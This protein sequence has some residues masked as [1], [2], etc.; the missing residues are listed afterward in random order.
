MA[1]TENTYT[2]NGATVLFTFTFPYLEQEHVKVSLDGVDTT[3]Y[4]FANATTVQMNSAPANGVIVRVYR[5]TY[6]DERITT[7]F[8]GSPIKASDL[9]SGFDQVL[10]VS[11][12]TRDNSIDK[13]DPAV[14]ADFDFNNNKGINLASPSDGADAA[15][16]AY[17]DSLIQ[18]G[19]A[20]AAAAAASA[21]AAATSASDA[22]ATYDDL[23]DR[24]LGPKASDPALDNNGNA[25]SVGA[26]YFNTTQDI[27]KAWTGT[28]WVISAAAGNIVRWRKTAS[29]GETV[30]S[31]NDDLAVTLDYAVGN[32]QVYLNGALQ[33]R[34]IDY[35]AATG[36]SITFAVALTVGD[37]VELHAVQGYVSGTL[38]PESIT[39]TEVSGAAAIDS[40][41]LAYGSRTVEA[42]LDDVVSVKD[43]GAVGD[44]V[45]DDTAAIQAAVNTGKRVYIPT[46]TYLCNVIITN[47]IILEGDGSSVS[48]LKPYNTATAAITYRAT[49][50]YWYYHSEVK[51]IGFNGIATKTGVGFA[52]GCTDP[53]LFAVPYH[54]AINVKFIGCHFLDLE[55]GVQFTFGNIGCEFYSCGF[56]FNK[57]GVYAL[58]NKFGSPPGTPAMHAG[59]HYFYSGEFNGNECGVYVHDT[60]GGGAWTFN[61]TVFEYNAIAV[62]AY[63]GGKLQTAPFIFD[64]QW[65][66]GNGVNMSLGAP[67][68][69]S[70]TVTIDAWSGSTRSDQTLNRRSFI[71][72]GSV[73]RADFRSCGVVGDIYLKAGSSSVIIDKCRT[74]ST[75]GYGGGACTVET[76]ESSVIHV[77]DAFTQDSIPVGDGII[78][79]GRL[80][81]V[82]STIGTGN[83]S[84]W[85]IT[86]RRGSKITSYGP[87][88]AMSA[89]LTTSASTS[90]SFPLTGTVVSDGQIYSQCNEFTRA[91]FAGNQ[92]TQLTNPA[93]SIT[94]TAGWYV[95][96]VDVKVTAGAPMFNVWNRSTA[97]FAR[98]M[99][100]PALN[101]WYTLAAIGYSPGSQTLYLDFSGPTVTADCTWRVSAYQI[102]RFDTLVEAQG[103]LESGAFVES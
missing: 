51:G 64:G 25:L 77:K 22:A 60:F 56:G 35:T 78:A 9:N 46:G 92:Y 81:N 39:N 23:D 29:G 31:G 65:L 87:A 7:F 95:F 94:T 91:S 80:F 17:V 20:S 24:Y 44:G 79:S 28:D 49:G 67:W 103:F 5:E 2:G 63:N 69:S 45:T 62:Y 18:T 89:T 83:Y 38:P 85:F 59:C 33:T 73:L 71:F 1:I 96:T 68:P 26:L 13:N 102:L 57:Y 84:R 76:P 90:G 36:S 98:A 37:V 8:T 12:E 53:S 41:K 101:K 32:E 34:G 66:E 4:T 30:L 3:A 97:Q 48:I 54:A 55:K 72:D 11:Q 100:V 99:S 42:K 15:N 10:Y 75:T 82:S 16:K 58:N 86:H 19:A 61:S 47:R 43:F 14:S 50:S 6:A 40:S 93:S 74:E 88:R 27:L 70:P 21:A 52:F